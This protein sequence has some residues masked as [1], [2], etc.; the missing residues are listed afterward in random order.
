MNDVR[1][2]ISYC[3]NSKNYYNREC[4]GT[5]PLNT[6]YT[7]QSMERV[8]RSFRK[9]TGNQAHHLVLCIQTEKKMGTN[10]KLSYAED[11]LY[12]IGNY[13]NNSGFQCVGYIHRKENYTI[14]YVPDVFENVHIHLIINSVN[15][16]TGLKL[17][18]IQ[19]FL[20]RILSLLRSEYPNL[21][22]NRVIYK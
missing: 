2:L 9:E 14:G 10:I 19:S 8:K 7:L 22:W 1:R 20:K 16:F 15:A 5:N 18:N 4:F 11:V 13:L 17:T 21:N 12:T 3:E 6:D